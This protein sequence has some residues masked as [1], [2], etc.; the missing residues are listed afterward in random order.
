MDEREGS[1]RLLLVESHPALGRDLARALSRSGFEVELRARLEEGL[2]GPDPRGYAARIVDPDA[3][4]ARRFLAEAEG[5]AHTV[6]IAA[7]A[8]SALLMRRML[9]GGVTLLRKPF[10]LHVL[11]EA[12]LSGLAPD[13]RPRRVLGDPLLATRDERLLEALDRA[14]CLARRSIAVCIEGELGTGRRALARALHD[15]SPRADGALVQVDRAMLESGAN[16][17]RDAFGLGE[18][19]ERARLG[20]L[21]LVEP[22]DWPHEA[23]QAL[24]RILA[25]RSESML[26]RLVSLASESLETSARAGRL[27]LELQYRLDAAR[28]VLPPLRDRVVDHEE[29]CRAVARR[30]AR[31]LG[32]A[33]PEIDASFV[34]RL[35]QE[36]FRGNRLGL[37]SRLRSVL[38]RRDVGARLEG[39]QLDVVA[40]SSTRH[41]PAAASLDLK[42]LER[43]TI[44]RA[45]AHWDGNR[46]RASE[47]LGISVRTLRNKIRE[48]GLR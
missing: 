27:P 32:V 44:I 40:V 43:D 34:E 46:T 19:L 18:A 2:E 39:A 35:A 36:G 48:Y 23:Q 29:L 42:A 11:E 12:V 4:G 9:G 17:P 8:S 33:T 47:S 14:R 38:M 37:E 3:E 6:L 24:A 22:A 13:A 31:E 21:L 25:A 28:L 5:F 16:D 20:S 15:W 30:V 41:V 45:L 1:L 10:A 26:P 7:D